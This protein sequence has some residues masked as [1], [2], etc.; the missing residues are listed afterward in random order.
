[1][2]D[3]KVTIT[4]ETLGKVEFNDGEFAEIEKIGV[5]GIEAC[6]LLDRIQID[7]SDTSY[8][9]RKFRRIFPAGTLLDV[10]TTIE[11]KPTSRTA[12]DLEEL[13]RLSEEEQRKFEE[14]I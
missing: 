12:R 5:E 6:L 4:K 10:S 11:V 13:E 8:S 2:N 14:H 1:M 9:R 3:Q 7:R